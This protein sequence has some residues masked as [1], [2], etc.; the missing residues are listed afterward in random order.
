M[1]EDAVAVWKPDHAD[2]CACQSRYAPFLP[3][4]HLAAASWPRT[5]LRKLRWR[6]CDGYR[7]RS[8]RR[9]LAHSRR[10]PRIRQHRG[11]TEP[12]PWPGRSRGR[13]SALR[14]KTTSA[15]TAMA[16]TVALS[17]RSSMCSRASRRP[18]G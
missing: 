5:A 9:P 13:A 16:W 18:A 7:S 6:R 4:E 14:G 15:R 10:R 1:A 2:H 12:I 17:S 11:G 8:Q 3:H